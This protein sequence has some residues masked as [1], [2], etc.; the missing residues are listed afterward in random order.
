[1]KKYILSALL[2]LALASGAYAQRTRDT[3]GPEGTVRLP[4]AGS[5]VALLGL[6]LGLIELGRR[7]FFKG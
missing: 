2:A 4:D 5:T 7:K 3:N 1:M 6:S